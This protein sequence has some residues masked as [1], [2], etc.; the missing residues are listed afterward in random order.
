VFVGLV[1]FFHGRLGQVSASAP[2]NDI[3][4]PIVMSTS[5][6]FPRDPDRVAGLQP[7][8]P[9]TGSVAVTTG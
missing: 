4:L 6:Y 7:G 2:I 1:F 5:I 3:D 9:A 8:Q